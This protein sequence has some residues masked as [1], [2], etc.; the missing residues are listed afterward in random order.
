MKASL[1]LLLLLF[2]LGTSAQTIGNIRS[3]QEG[4]KI[5]VYYQILKSTRQQSFKVE[6]KCVINDQEKVTLKYISGDVGDTVY[7]GKEEYKV[8]WDVLSEVDELTS[9]EFIVS[10]TEN[11]PPDKME[12]LKPLN[13]R[14]WMVAYH[15]NQHTPLGV[16]F[17]FMRS[18]GFYL[19]GSLGRGTYYNQSY[20]VGIWDE[21]SSVIGM[22]TAGL[23]KR[24]ILNDMYGIHAYVGGGLTNSWYQHF[25]ILYYENI[26]QFKYGYS[27]NNGHCTVIEGGLAAYLW[28]G[29]GLNVGLARL[30]HTFGENINN[31]IVRQ[32]ALRFTFGLN[33]IF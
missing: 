5:N 22:G 10:I 33:Y 26:D 7:G 15:F 30:Q 4:E 1:T 20:L 31:E 18:F 16:R 21:N 11:E 19:S 25:R 2:A 14:K 13:K 8:V 9:A 29:Y 28:N 12:R 27:L 3:E 32:N 6:L 24:I 17:A 23:T